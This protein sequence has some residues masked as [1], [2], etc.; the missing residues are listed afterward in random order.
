M[1][2]SDNFLMKDFSI[3]KNYLQTVNVP[4][5]WMEILGKM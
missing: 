1:P 2:Y 5:Q 4:I 3:L